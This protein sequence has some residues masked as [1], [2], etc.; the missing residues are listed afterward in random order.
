MITGT[1]ENEIIIYIVLLA[2]VGRYCS[3]L[4]ARNIVD[5]ALLAK[6]LLLPHIPFYVCYI[7]ETRYCLHHDE[8]KDVFAAGVGLETAEI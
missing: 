8:S 5:L 7:K 6:S 1:L 4:A 3:Q 2:V